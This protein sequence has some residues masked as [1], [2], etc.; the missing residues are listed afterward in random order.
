MKQHEP[1]FLVLEYI[2]ITKD[3]R[4]G[5]V[6]VGGTEKAADIL[7]RTGASFPRRAPRDLS[8]A[9]ARSARRAATSEGDHRLART[10]R[11]T[12]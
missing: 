10:A 11:R 7:Q 4:T 1:D 9:A 3:P 6:V 8:P 12:Q 5:L 2:T